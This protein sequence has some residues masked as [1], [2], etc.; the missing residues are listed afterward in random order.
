M[1]NKNFKSAEEYAAACEKFFEDHPEAPIAKDV[2]CLS[3]IMKR[4]YAEQILAGTKK[5]EFRSYSNFY[6]KRL[7][8]PEVSDFIRANFNN[9]EVIMFCNDI[10]QV[11]KIHFHN[12][13]NSWFLDIECDYNDAF[14]INKHDVEFLQKEYGCHDFDEDLKRMDANK[15]PQEK[16]PWLFYLVCGKVLD[17]NLEAK[18]Q[19][20][21]STKK[22]RVKKVYS[23]A[24]VEMVPEKNDS[25]VLKFNVSKET[26]KNIVDG[27]MKEFTKEL[28]PKNL[29]IFFIMNE[30]GKVKEIN[31]IPQLRPYDA[32]QFINKEDSYKCQI[33]NADVMFEDE[34]YGNTTRYCDLEDDESV[35]YT[36]CIIA[37]ALGEK[38]K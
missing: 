4:E 38:V 33:N 22:S 27:S 12:Y 21:E 11:K 5:L 26:F 25:K 35:D 14:R 23:S 32:I 2:E 13:N 8:D 15:V 17:T 30:D 18:P 29:S 28:T 24:A 37:Y 6:V 31:G 9:D 10:R 16:R 20:R 36:D 1:S 7:I 3:L 19:I 34:E